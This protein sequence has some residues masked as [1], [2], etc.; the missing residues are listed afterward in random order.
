[1]CHHVVFLQHRGFPHKPVHIA[2]Y[3]HDHPASM[4]FPHKAVPPHDFVSVF[5]V[6][7]L[8]MLATHLVVFIRRSDLPFISN[9][10]TAYTRTGY[11]VSLGLPSG[12]RLPVGYPG[13]L[14]PG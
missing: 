1:M 10:E 6:S 4:H 5:Q 7:S 3:P 12:T 8:R 11:W 14:L 13:N 9:V 2:L